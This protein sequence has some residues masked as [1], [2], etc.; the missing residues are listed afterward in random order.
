MI[1]RFL[2]HDPEELYISSITYAE[3]MHGV[4][5]SMA[6]ERNRIALYLILSTITILKFNEQTPKKYGRTVQNLKK[7]YTDLADGYVNSRAGHAMARGLILVT[8]DRFKF[9]VNYKN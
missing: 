6:V 8:R 4:E 7:G 9:C 1:I 5:K 3:L 2:S